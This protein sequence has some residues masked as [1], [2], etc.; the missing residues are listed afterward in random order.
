MVEVRRENRDRVVADPTI[1]LDKFDWPVEEPLRNPFDPLQALTRRRV[2]EPAEIDEGARPLTELELEAFR[3]VVCAGHGRFLDLLERRMTSLESLLSTHQEEALIE[4]DRQVEELR[5]V[6]PETGRTQLGQVEGSIRDPRVFLSAQIEARGHDIADP[7]RLVVEES[8][9][10]LE[11]I[12]ARF[13]VIEESLAEVAEALA[14]A[15]VRRGWTAMEAAFRE[16]NYAR[17]SE[18]F[19]EKMVPVARSPHAA[20]DDVHS[21][22]HEGGDLDRRARIRLEFE[23]LA[24]SVSAI[25]YDVEDP[26]RTVFL[27]G[28]P[29]RPRGI[30][31]TFRVDGAPEPLV[32]R[33]VE[34]VDP[35]GGPA[36]GMI[37]IYEYR[38][39]SIRQ[40]H[41]TRT[42]RFES[43]MKNGRGPR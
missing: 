31:E 30:G 7:D 14:M 12:R 32:I 29:A 21:L 13:R 1:A 2:I 18:I 9:A 36:G 15:R 6:D 41:E 24:V 23:N 16:A 28:S 5:Q 10:R 35:E 4:A 22:L 26:T 39:E 17:V 40:K 34:L 37:L 19:A 38:G 42:D 25:I 43:E 8:L 27:L 3:E 20:R 33:S 11:E